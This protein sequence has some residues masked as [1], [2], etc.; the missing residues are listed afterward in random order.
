LI[1]VSKGFAG[2]LPASGD[3]CSR[4]GGIPCQPLA[5]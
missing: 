3:I 5:V 2:D 1:M 4:Y